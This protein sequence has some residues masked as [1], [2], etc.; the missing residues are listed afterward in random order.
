ML[1][2]YKKRGDKVRISKKEILVVI[3]ILLIAS[4]AAYAINIQ[5]IRS[6]LWSDPDTWN[7][8]QVPGPIDDV[9]ITAGTNVTREVHCH[10][11]GPDIIVNSL[12]VEPSA[13]LVSNQTQDDIGEVLHIT[14]H[15]IT[16]YG[17]I[18]A[19]GG[20]STGG[21]VA[22]VLDPWFTLNYNTAPPVT[23]EITEP[24]ELENF[25]VIEAGNAL[26]YTYLD[27]FIG[28]AVVVW[29]RFHFIDYDCDG[30]L[31]D[32]LWINPTVFN[33]ADAIMNGGIARDVGGTITINAI[34]LTNEGLIKGGNNDYPPRHVAGL[35]GW[36]FIY[37]QRAC[38]YSDL[39]GTVYLNAPGAVSFLNTGQVSGGADL[40]STT[41]QPPGPGT[42]GSVWISCEGTWTNSGEITGGDG[43][44]GG[45]VACFSSTWPWTNTE[46][47]Q[48]IAGSSSCTS[49]PGGNVC[50]F[51]SPK[52]NR[53]IIRAGDGYPAGN[54]IDPMIME[55][56]NNAEIWGEDCKLGGGNV[57]HI[58]LYSL[59]HKPTIEVEGDLQI[60]LPPG[61]TLEIQGC[62]YD[63][64][65][66]PYLA[67]AGGDI[68]IHADEINIG[69][70]L[71]LGDLF[72]PYPIIESGSRF[73]YVK[74]GP[75]GMVIAEPG[76]ESICRAE[77]INMGT[78]SCYV[79]WQISSDKGW[80]VNPQQG[81][82]SLAPGQKKEIELGI[83]IPGSVGL[84]EYD[85]VLLHAEVNEASQKIAE[86]D[87]K[88]FIFSRSYSKI[89]SLCEL[90]T[91]WLSM[92]SEP[93]WNVYYNTNGDSIINLGDFAEFAMWWLDRETI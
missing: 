24:G 22:L 72:S 46:S 41:L 16:N 69:C 80:L 2:W 56:S 43:E 19:E 68:V 47:G 39:L 59:I 84:S 31:D 8:Q 89:A 91:T 71:G 29:P 23:V 1:I 75:G 25:G 87:S 15:R 73:A 5:S 17:T 67:S 44:L 88:L 86:D 50:A 48:I 54:V 6:G 18:R 32:M 51:G 53:G 57:L 21:F 34:N 38:V 11:T 74:I 92:P 27:G 82:E 9:T 49:I 20:Y 64:N 83:Q 78:K 60:I 76:E 40:S 90:A 10:L 14:A 37:V 35:G 3:Y 58:D 63:A 55:L 28:G 13:A 85:V 7:P 45:S 81:S 77:V 4:N 70:G 36:T 93:G 66:P 65:E 79:D 30:N 52:V 12:T 42:G 26:G 61:G 62:P 33:H